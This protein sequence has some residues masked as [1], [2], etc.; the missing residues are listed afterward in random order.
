M[1]PVIYGGKE[2]EDGS[3]NKQNAECQHGVLHNMSAPPRTHISIA[4]L[5]GST[6]T[7]ISGGFVQASQGLYS[8]VCVNLLLKKL[9]GTSIKIVST[10]DTLSEKE[11]H[12][13]LRYLI[14][15][16][17]IATGEKHHPSKQAVYAMASYR[18]EQ[19]EALYINLTDTLNKQTTGLPPFALV[20]PRCAPILRGSLETRPVYALSLISRIAGN[21]FSIGRAPVIPDDSILVKCFSLYT[22]TGE[23]R[24]LS[25]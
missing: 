19:L 23:R 12:L 13:Y 21:I 8:T 7:F 18:L 4:P 10:R 16:A 9:F 24:S 15:S 22:F 3:V 6:G 20:R 17:R 2:S 11:R 1:A 5:T 25:S 14:E